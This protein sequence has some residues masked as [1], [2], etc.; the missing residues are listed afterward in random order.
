MN[1]AKFL[2]KEVML[3][4]GFWETQE[5]H[6]TGAAI[7]ELANATKRSK[8]TKY[9]AP[10]QVKT[11]VFKYDFNMDK[12]TIPKADNDISEFIKD[13]LVIDIKVNRLD[14]SHIAYVVT[15]K[16]VPKV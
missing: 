16:Y 11:F 14:E 15:Y 9:D 6:E 7:R 8:A 13:K 1:S 3:M 4:S 2:K 12:G 5:G 10:M